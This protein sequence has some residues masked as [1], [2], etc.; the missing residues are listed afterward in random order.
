MI[1]EGYIR[2]IKKDSGKY[3]KIYLKLKKSVLYI[4]ENDKTERCQNT[5][6]IEEIEEVKGSNQTRPN[7]VISFRGLQRVK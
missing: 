5:I 2:R 6:Q 7:F 1:S 4:Y 3:E